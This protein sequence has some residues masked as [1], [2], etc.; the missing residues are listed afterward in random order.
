MKI[1]S[2][3]IGKKNFAYCIEDNDKLVKFENIDLT[4]GVPESKL[5][6]FLHPQIFTNLS[7]HFDENIIDIADCD[8]IVIE[9]QMS[10]GKKV[11]PMALKIGQ[12]TFSYFLL[13]HPDIAIIE[14][15]SYYKTQLN[16]APTKMNYTQRKQWAIHKACEILVDRGDYENLTRLTCS[17]K[18]DDLA[19][20]VCQSQAFKISLK[21]NLEKITSKIYRNDVEYSCE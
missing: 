12:H 11:N 2:I 16:N 9:Q 21:M 1:C 19:D 17:K 14:F 6:S 18:M 13:T 15:P 5:K 4:E 20:V 3:D 7:K 8:Y 10:F